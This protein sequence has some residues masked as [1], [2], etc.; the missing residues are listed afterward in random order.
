MSKLKK[1]VEVV[2]VVFGLVCCLDLYLEQ[3]TGSGLNILEDI[4]I[5]IILLGYSSFS[6]TSREYIDFKSYFTQL[7][8][9][10]MVFCLY[11]LSQLGFYIFQ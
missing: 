3:F 8:P 1:V 9:F 5:Y 7:T 11:V 10:E 2:F 4:Y 6:F